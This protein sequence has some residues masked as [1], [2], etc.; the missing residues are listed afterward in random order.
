MRAPLSDLQDARSYLQVFAPGL[1]LQL[2]E[3]HWP[4]LEQDEPAG[5]SVQ[6]PPGPPPPLYSA[7]KPD[8][9]SASMV[10]GP[11]LQ[12]E[13]DGYIVEPETFE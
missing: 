5:S 2:P 4:L 1:P 13:T 11:L 7:F 3:Q 6:P 9:S 12:L 10:A 8:L